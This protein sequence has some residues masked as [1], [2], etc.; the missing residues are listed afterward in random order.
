[1]ANKKEGAATATTTAD[2][3]D[4]PGTTGTDDS[5]SVE[6]QAQEQTGQQQIRLRIDQSKMT[7]CYANAFR[8]G[9][10]AE[11]IML[12]FGLNQVIQAR[13]GDQDP[14][15]PAGEILFQINDRIV[16]NYYT[17]KRLAITLGQLIRRY[18]DQF[19]ELQLNVADR[20]KAK[21]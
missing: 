5:P 20:A 13:Q 14:G 1:M 17:A 11:E 19:G 12:D 4:T 18:E 8:S 3:P 7:T 16:L 10:T 2:T 9:T 15:Q 6:T 21:S